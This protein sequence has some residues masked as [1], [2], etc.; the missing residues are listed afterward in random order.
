MPR[1]RRSSWQNV[2]SVF[3]M[4]VSATIFLHEKAQGCDQPKI[5]ATTQKWSYSVFNPLV[6]I[7]IRTH[8][9]NLANMVTL[10]HCSLKGKNT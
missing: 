8:I 7:A 10:F 4:N 2:K 9:S 5:S 6:K 3:L 1:R